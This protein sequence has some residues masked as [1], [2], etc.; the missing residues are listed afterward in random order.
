MK[1]TNVL[2]YSRQTIGI[3]VTPIDTIR[4]M[5]D[6]GGAVHVHVT[7]SLSSTPQA[8]RDLGNWDKLFDPNADFCKQY[9]MSSLMSSFKLRILNLFHFTFFPLFWYW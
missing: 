2:A 5:L 7:R 9:I 3:Q 4:L 1:W 8:K 6:W